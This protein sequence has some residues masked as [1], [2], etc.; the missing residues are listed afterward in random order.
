MNTSPMRGKEHRKSIL[1]THLSPATLSPLP[2]LRDRRPSAL[3]IPSRVACVSRGPVRAQCIT[4]YKQKS[5]ERNIMRL[6]ML[7]RCN[8][9][10]SR[11]RLPA[12]GS[13]S[14]MR[15]SSAASSLAG[16]AFDE[17]FAP[18]LAV[19][20]EVSSY[21][22]GADQRGNNGYIIYRGHAPSSHAP[23]RI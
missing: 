22:E 17:A 18:R 6:T 11:N 5:K 16:A 20:N 8:T 9:R 7:F 4:S 2:R 19:P 10:C 14:R 3:R 21:R 23:R 1:R 15:A 12:A 13:A